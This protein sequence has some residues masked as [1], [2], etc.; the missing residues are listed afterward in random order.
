MVNRSTEFNQIPFCKPNFRNKNAVS[1]T[2]LIR[3]AFILM[4]SMQRNVI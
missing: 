3:Y 4:H 2:K 1:Q